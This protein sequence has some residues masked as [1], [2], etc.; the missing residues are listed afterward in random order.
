[1]SDIV[2]RLTLLESGAR[3]QDEEA[4]DTIEAASDEIERLQARV[5]DAYAEGFAAAREMAARE[6]D[7][8]RIDIAGKPRAV[9]KAELI[10]LSHHIRAL[11]PDGDA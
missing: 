1:M 7:E 10:A 5:A 9:T 2:K 4:A 11:R 8:L 6:L 3:W